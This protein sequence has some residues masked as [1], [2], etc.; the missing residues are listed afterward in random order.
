[1]YV[2]SVDLRKDE[3]GEEKPSL[4]STESDILRHQELRIGRGPNRVGWD[5]DG[6]DCGFWARSK[7]RYAVDS[8]GKHKDKPWHKEAMNSF[9]PKL[10]L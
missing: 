9:L 4:T 1:M 8:V 2:C 10:L 5:G 6:I 3:E 7:K